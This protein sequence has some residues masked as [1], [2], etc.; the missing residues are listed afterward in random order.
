VGVH[1]CQEGLTGQFI[2]DNDVV[3][4]G[5]FFDD[6]L[7][8]ALAVIRPS[9]AR[10]MDRSFKELKL[11]G[12]GVI[13]AVMGR[14]TTAEARQLAACRTEGSQ[15]IALLLDVATWAGGAR[16]AGPRNAAE[17]TDGGP[18]TGEADADSDAAAETDTA[19]ARRPVSARPAAET[20]AAAAIL[21]SAG[22][23]VTNMDVDTP[24]ANAWQRLPRAAEML[25]ATGTTIHPGT[26]SYPATDRTD[27]GRPA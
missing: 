18:G 20:A 12:A 8:D 4:A 17:L 26:D 7:L 2:T 3:R 13:V 19:A 10:T 11:S 9:G 5:P 21:R 22:W 23:H 27:G 1:V 6:R 14:L 25:V 16:R 24:L 15:G